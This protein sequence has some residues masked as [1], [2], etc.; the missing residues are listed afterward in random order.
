[1]KIFQKRSLFFVLP[2]FVATA[3]LVTNCSDD[4]DNPVTA[5]PQPII[6]TASETG[7]F[8]TF[9]SLVDTTNL[10][11]KLTNEGPFTVFM[12]TDS[13]FNALDSVTLN[14]LLAD[15]Q[16]LEQVIQYHLVPGNLT[17]EQL[18]NL[19]QVVTVEGSSIS[20]S[21]QG[22]TI[23]LNDSVRIVGDAINASNGVIYPI[24]GVLIPT[25]AKNPISQIVASLP[26]FT[27]LDSALTAADLVQT[28]SGAGPFTVFAPTDSAF[29]ALPAGTLDSLFADTTGMLSNVLL[30]HTVADSL[31]TSNLVMLDSVV[32]IQGTAISISVQDSTI[33]LNDSIQIVFSNIEASNGVIH[34]IDGV[35]LP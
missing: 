28:L 11:Q 7:N 15:S 27:K 29:D 16:L 10:T 20:I 35:L 6:Q 25:T 23:I 4:D 3:F 14:T 24:N 1:M 19:Q 18:S 5:V 34:A 9:I 2:L 21:V 13:A 8:S 17:K 30:Y 33:I 31:M 32:T 26:Q 22:D 12:P